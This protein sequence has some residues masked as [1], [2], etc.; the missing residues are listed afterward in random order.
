VF[1]CG[2]FCDLHIYIVALRRYA[3]LQDMHARKLRESRNLKK[4]I[5]NEVGLRL[6]LNDE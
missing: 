4:E 2:S 6:T 1:A 5:N 3:N